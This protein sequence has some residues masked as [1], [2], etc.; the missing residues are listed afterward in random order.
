MTAPAALAWLDLLSFPEPEDERGA[1]EC[2]ERG[3]PP[4]IVDPGRVR[5]RENLVRP[6]V[7][8]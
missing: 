2:H 5:Q 7:L 6:E 1:F 4:R 3:V 8:L